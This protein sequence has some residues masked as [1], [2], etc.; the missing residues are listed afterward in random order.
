VVKLKKGIV[1]LLLLAVGFL[2]I[3]A[4][5]LIGMNVLGLEWWRIPLYVLFSYN[6]NALWMTLLSYLCELLF[7]IGVIIFVLGV[8]TLFNGN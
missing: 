8:Y 1:I 2:L 4:A 6:F 7:F 5:F 3:A